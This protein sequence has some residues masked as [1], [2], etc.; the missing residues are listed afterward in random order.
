M[1]VV[2]ST[3]GWLGPMLETILMML[4]LGIIPMAVIVTVFE[5]AAKRHQHQ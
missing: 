3:R 1:F 2:G 4:V 5:V